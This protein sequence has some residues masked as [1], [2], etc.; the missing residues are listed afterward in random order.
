MGEWL[1]CKNYA[2]LVFR[3]WKRCLGSHKGLISGLWCFAVLQGSSHISLRTTKFACGSESGVCE[4]N[5]Y[6]PQEL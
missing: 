5:D 4:Q 1:L 3:V 2:S 6:G